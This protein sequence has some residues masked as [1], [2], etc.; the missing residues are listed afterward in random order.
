MA[1]VD[2]LH[3][4]RNQRF[5]LKNRSEP[6]GSTTLHNHSVL[7]WHILPR[8]KTCYRSLSSSPLL[9]LFPPPPFNSLS[10]ISS[11]LSSHSHF[12]KIHSPDFSK[13]LP[14]WYIPTQ[15]LNLN[16]TKA[17]VLK[18][19]ETSPKD[20]PLLSLGGPTTYPSNR[21]LPTSTAISENNGKKILDKHISTIFI[22][23]HN[24]IPGFG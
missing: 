22:P 6:Q 17:K 4:K 18:N 12:S 13:T 23:W 15:N 20:Y 1:K 10:N 5:I 11:C 2:T 16:P 19:G 21:F 14:V 24:Q 7:I 8:S 9:Y 3:F